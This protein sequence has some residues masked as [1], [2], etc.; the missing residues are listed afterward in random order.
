MRSSKMYKDGPTVKKDEETGRPVV[1]KKD[2][3]E[4]A[5][6]VQ[7]GVDGMK[8]E[9]VSDQHA[10]ERMEMKH[11]HIKEHIDMHTKHAHEH[12]HHKGH[13]KPLHEKHER[14]HEEMHKRHAKEMETM[15]GRHEKEMPGET[16]E[17]LIEKSKEKAE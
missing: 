11:R 4:K 13:K 1:A 14:E 3:Q 7:E 2:G 16:G 9:H 10:G 17:K 12:M 15:H 6:R 8:I 5:D